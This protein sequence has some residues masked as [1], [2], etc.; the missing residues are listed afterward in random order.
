MR[1]PGLLLSAREPFEVEEGSPKGMLAVPSEA[2]TKDRM[3]VDEVEHPGAVGV[4]V[5]QFQV[6]D[7]P[8]SEPVPETEHFGDRVGPV[9]FLAL[10]RVHFYRLPSSIEFEPDAVIETDH[11]R[12]RSVSFVR[13]FCQSTYKPMMCQEQ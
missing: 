12:H 11:S 9:V 1:E 10:G 4:V 3:G 5:T 7:A 6:T 2:K 13:R 8:S